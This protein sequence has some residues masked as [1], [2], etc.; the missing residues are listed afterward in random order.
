MRLATVLGQVVATVKEPG[1]GRFTLLVVQDGSPADSDAGAD[2]DPGP[3][4]RPPY[5]A[6][7]LVG[8]GVGE[9]VLVVGGSAARLA[10]GAAAGADCPTDQAVVGI[11]DTVI[12]RGTVTYRKS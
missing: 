5:V 8:A 9:L 1:L 4:G 10:A 3:P 2:S 11:A 6:V 7:D 12:E